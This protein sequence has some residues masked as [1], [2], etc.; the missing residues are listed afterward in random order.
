MLGVLCLSYH[1]I[2]PNTEEGN[3]SWDWDLDLIL[4]R[5]TQLT[6]LP[7][8]RDKPSSVS[9]QSLAFSFIPFT[10]PHNKAG[11]KSKENGS[12]CRNQ[13][14]DSVI[15]RR[16]CSEWVNRDKEWSW[17]ITWAKEFRDQVGEYGKNGAETSEGTEPLF[18]PFVLQR[19]SELHSVGRPGKKSGG[20]EQ[21][22]SE[23]C[24]SALPVLAFNNGKQNKQP[25]NKQTNKNP[26][27]TKP[28]ESYLKPIEISTSLEKEFG[29]E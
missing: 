17:P 15:H 26:Q 9:L 29:A 5:V 10:F 18:S 21:N 13:G 12:E 16:P 8:P 4:L 20:H 27:K 7:Q 25:K 2:L 6:K 28:M 11:V 1:L 22:S 3:D 24:S 23:K 14:G 19:I